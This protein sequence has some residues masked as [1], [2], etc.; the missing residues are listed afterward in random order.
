PLGRATD[1]H[2]RGAGRSEH[3]LG[4]RPGSDVARRDDGASDQVDGLGRQRM[5]GLAC[6]H[7]LRRA[8]VE[9]QRSGAGVD[10]T[11]RQV[12]ARPCAVFE[13]SAPP[14]R[15]GTR[16][17]VGAGGDDRR[18]ALGVLEQRRAGARLRDLL[19]G[20]PEVDV[21]EIGA[22][23][24]HHA[25]GLGHGGRV[26]PEDLDGQ[27]VL[28][29]GDAEVAERPLVAV[30]EPGA[31]DHLGADE[32]GAETAPLPTKGLHADP[33]HRREHDA[34]RDLDGP[35]L[36]LRR[37]IDLHRARNRSRVSLTSSGGIGTMPP[38]RG[39]V[40][41]P[42]LFCWELRRLFVKEVI[43]TPEG[44]KKLKEEIEYLS[45]EKR[46][47]VADRIRIAREFGDITENAEYD[48][49]K[50]EQ[51]MLE[52]RI[53]QLEER[54]LAARVIDKKEISKD[55]V[56]VGSHVR[57]RDV[58]AKETVEYHI[59]DSA[60]ANPAEQ[61]LSNESPV[62]RAIIGK[63]KGETVEVS[64]PRGSLKYKILEIKA[65]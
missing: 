34:R 6:V 13:P 48:H 5:V 46:R 4:S 47:E 52:H 45:T 57:L 49:A 14:H 59:V 39:P 56:S 58:A 60:E 24:F 3:R 53:A 19:H 50:N 9:R 30:L 15:H 26:R 54:L 33:C 31:A 62:G 11:R 18:G 44:Y 65:A 17:G 28:V 7:L 43:L 35:D 29:R 10:E 41:G 42:R 38:P 23:G 2:R 64:T 61:K 16:D 12:E 8:R 22:C 21:D 55:V 20:A 1:H 27:R 25:R 37:Q 51:A 40:F 36:P 32:T 63:K